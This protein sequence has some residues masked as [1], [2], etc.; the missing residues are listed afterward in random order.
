MGECMSSTPW[1][2]SAPIFIP[3]AHSQHW[4][5]CGWLHRKQQ[6]NKVDLD[7]KERS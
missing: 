6:W 1:L 3:S 5:G 4:Q 2:A 7:W